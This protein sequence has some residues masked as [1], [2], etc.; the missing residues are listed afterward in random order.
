MILVDIGNTSLHFGI[1]KDS[2]IINNFRIY[3]KNISLKLLKNTLAKYSENKIIVCS[4]APSVTAYFRKLNRK[5]YF[6]GEDIIVPV[7]SLYN[8][9]EV[10]EDRLVNAFTAREIYPEA[11][12]IIDFGT[13]ITI[14]FLSKCSNYSGGFI[15]PGIELYLN[16]LSCCELLPKTTILTTRYSFIPKNSAQSISQGLKEGFSFM[17]NGFVKKYKKLIEKKQNRKIKIIVTGGQS[18]ILR[19]RLKFSYIYVPLLTLKGL[20]LLSLSSAKE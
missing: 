12:M 5:V 2:K 10:G 15:L 16:S 13:A 18:N 4:V 7:K 1:E 6:V 11:K 3:N 14:D 8:E 17:L 20:F 9:Q 19:Q